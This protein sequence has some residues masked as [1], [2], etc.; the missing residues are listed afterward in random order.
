MATAELTICEPDRRDAE[1]FVT[2][3]FADLI[4]DLDGTETS[5]SSDVFRGGQRHAE[6]ALAELDLSRYTR[7][8]NHAYPRRQRAATGLSP[9]D[10]LDASSS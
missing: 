5:L 2:R 6:K 3:H 7:D 9:P 1:R 8:R 10:G 4:G